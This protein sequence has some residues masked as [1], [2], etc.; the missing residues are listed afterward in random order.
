M[1]S[2]VTGCCPQTPTTPEAAQI[3]S[4]ASGKSAP[5]GFTTWG[6]FCQASCS[7]CVS[8]VA[9]RAPGIQGI[10]C[11]IHSSVCSRQLQG[12]C[13]PNSQGHGGTPDAL[14]SSEPRGPR[15]RGVLGRDRPQHVWGQGWYS[16]A[17]VGTICAWDTAVTPS[18][19]RVGPHEGGANRAW[20]PAQCLWFYR[21]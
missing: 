7:V 17:R 5:L 11:S 18:Q 15:D 2:H 1:G 8:S 4:A 9:F 16:L 12:S 20:F 6:G 21:P 10:L 14:S 3:P 13:H 19:G